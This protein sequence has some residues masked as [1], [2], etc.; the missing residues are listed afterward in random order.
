MSGP[1]SAVPQRFYKHLYKAFGPQ[2]WWPARSPF[3]VMAGA[4]LTQ[5]TSWHNVELA[6]ARLKRTGP[7]TPHRIAAMPLSGLA[8][9]V[10]PA[11]FFRQK[12]QRFSRFARWYVRRYGGR[13]AAMFRG[14]W[15]ATRRE[16][17]SLPGI[18][19][20]TADA[21]LLY[22]GALPVF[23][24]DAYTT[25]IF[26]RHRL[27]GRRATYG[28][29]Q[30]LVMRSM[31]ARAGTYNEFHALLVEVGKRYCRRRQPDCAHCPL[32]EFPHSKGEG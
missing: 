27:I 31:R 25:R 20:E 19:P 18:G 30:R 7:L 15:P 13:P 2:G 12:A 17:L 10:R 11:G 4:M 9:A 26:R 16:L 6:L 21:I 3:E 22:A 28:Q 23:V 8:R 24:V 14:R 29:I 1:R 32:G 5:A